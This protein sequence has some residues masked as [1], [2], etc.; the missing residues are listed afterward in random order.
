MSPARWL[1]R[2]LLWA[3]ALLAAGQT[4]SAEPARRIISLAPFLTEIAYAAGAGERLVGAVSY[5]D[6]PPAARELPRVGG[7]MKIDLEATLALKPDLILAWESGNPPS[8]L[9]QLEALGIPVLVA[10][11]RSFEAIAALIETVG[12]RA[13]TATTARRE[14]AVFRARLQRLR[15]R[16][17]AAD[18][19]SVFYQIW[20]QPLMTINGEHL[21]SAAIGLCGGRNIF[22][23]MQPLS[24]EVSLE[25]VLDADPQAIIASGMG[26][27]RPEWLDQWRRWPWLQAVEKGHLF[28]IPPALIQR[29]SPRILEGTARLCRQLEQVRRDVRR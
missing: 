16:Y 3:L 17:A 5:S 26:E 25:A 10:E 23:G 20:H 27:A 14:A 4:L 29:H 22:A 8:A 11:P 13:G 24:T 1:S 18:T 19:V 9:E 2:A 21:I 12:A 7:Y 28:F 15:K 6:Y